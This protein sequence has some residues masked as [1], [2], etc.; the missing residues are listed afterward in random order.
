MVLK[1]AET[2]EAARAG[3]VGCAGLLLGFMVVD[4]VTVSLGVSALWEFCLLNA[5]PVNLLVLLAFI[6]KMFIIQ[7]S[8]ALNVPVV[9]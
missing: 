3:V 9:I 7:N 8:V 4:V 6:F 2:V 1:A 5:V